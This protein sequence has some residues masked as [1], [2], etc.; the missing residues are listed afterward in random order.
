MITGASLIFPSSCTHQVIQ[1]PKRKL[2]L[3]LTLEGQ[4]VSVHFATLS[5]SHT[6]HTHSLTHTLAH[7]HTRT[8]THHTHPP[9]TPTLTHLQWCTTMSSGHLSVS[10]GRRTRL[11]V[12]MSTLPASRSRLT[13][14][15]TLKLPRCSLGMKMIWTIRTSSPIIIETQAH[16]H[17]YS[18]CSR[19][20][21]C[22]I[23]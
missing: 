12:D 13:L 21:C 10:P 23:G 19:Q 22:V 6:H 17:S 8:L 14:H 9:H 4:K 7:P 3:E 1:R 20:E 16:T 5:P 18:A 15:P 2:E 11:R